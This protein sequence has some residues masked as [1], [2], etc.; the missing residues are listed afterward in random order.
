[1]CHV[2]FWARKVL[3]FT[4]A[5][6]GCRLEVQPVSYKRKVLSVSWMV[7]ASEM[8]SSSWFPD[9]RNVGS[10]WIPT[11]PYSSR[12][13][14]GSTSCLALVAHKRS[15]TGWWLGEESSFKRPLDAVLGS[16]SLKKAL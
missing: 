10:P 16:T 7:D 1:M 9:G 3:S 6:C 5:L 8:G 13:L 12:P 15:V 2:S 14:W 11:S 4:M